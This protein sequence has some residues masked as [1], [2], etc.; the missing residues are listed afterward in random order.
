MTQASFNGAGPSNPGGFR[1]VRWREGYRI[2][3]VDALLDRI[4]AGAVTSDEVRSA[5]L[6]PVRL[7]PGYDMNDVDRYLDRT[8]AELRASGR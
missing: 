6:R 8:E 3:E 5:R 2:D 7:K 1:I 4:A